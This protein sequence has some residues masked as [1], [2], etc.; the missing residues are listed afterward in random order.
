MGMRSIGALEQFT[1]E[2]KHRHALPHRRINHA[3]LGTQP[4]AAR[5]VP[6]STV[7]DGMNTKGLNAINHEQNT[8][9]GCSTGL[10][11]L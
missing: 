5:T 11:F 6:T 2:N 10:L 7:S 9:G 3:R 1:D 8:H 4:S